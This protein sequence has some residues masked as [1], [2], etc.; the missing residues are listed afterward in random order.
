MDRFGSESRLM[1]AANMQMP[2]RAFA[3]SENRNAREE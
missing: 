3:V 1:M 2:V